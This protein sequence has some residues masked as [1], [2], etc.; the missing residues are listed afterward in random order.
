MNSRKKGFTLVELLAVIVILGIIFAIALPN[1][2]TIIENMRLDALRSSAAMMIKAAEEHVLQNNITTN[3]TRLTLEA[4]GTV[5]LR[6]RLEMSY[7]NIDVATTASFVCVTFSGTPA[8]P[9]YRVRLAE[10]TPS[11]R[12]VG[13]TRGNITTTPGLT[14]CP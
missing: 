6:P 12:A 1:V 5:T 9:S 4:T 7:T 11:T 8:L 13:G 3:P 2:L 14:T 10:L